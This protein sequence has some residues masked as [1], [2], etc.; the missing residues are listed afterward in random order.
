MG[1]FSKKDEFKR[2]LLKIIGWKLVYYSF[3][4]VLPLIMVPQPAW[5]TLL[6]FL[7]MHF[8][9]GLSISL[10][11]QTAHIMPSSQ[12]PL[13][14]KNGVMSNEWLVHQM[15]T[16]TNYSPCSRLFSW[17]IGGLNYQLE[18]HLLPHVCHVHYKKLSK[19]VADTAREFNIPYNTKPTFVAAVIDHFKMLRHLGRFQAQA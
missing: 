2:E 6:G 1:F 16:T 15:A 5:I 3:A 13:P 9:T 7:T 4:L 10:V 8:V 17:F 14:D 12:F 11:F 19:V 18:H